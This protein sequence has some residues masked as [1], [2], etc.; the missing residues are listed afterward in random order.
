M[1]HTAGQ[2]T[3]I[4]LPHNNKDKRGDKRWFTISSSPTEDLV[5]ITTKFSTDPSSSF[6]TT[7]QALKPGDELNLA[8]PMGDFILPKDQ[9]IP[10]VFVAGG[11]GCTPYRSII[12][13]LI[14]S[15]EERDITLLYAA[16]SQQEVAFKD[17]FASLGNKFKII[18][19]ERL[20]AQMIK[21][22]AQATPSHYIYLSGPEPM[23]EELDKDLKSSGIN[24]KQIHT[25]FFPGY[26]A[27]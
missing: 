24:K 20:N 14:D 16:N 21:D 4:R 6:K 11:I 25:D 18:V 9:T 27:I 13:Y 5:S 15:K 7:L 1:R 2:F 17:I 22:L 23:V 8:S 19:G 10:L 3:E 12:K 26:S